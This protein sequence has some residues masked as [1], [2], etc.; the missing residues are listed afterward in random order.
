MT[1]ATQ[2]QTLRDALD[3]WAKAEGGSALIARDPV[4]MSQAIL[5]ARLKP[6]GIL[7]VVMFKAEEAV[8]D[9]PAAG[10]VR[11]TFTV[12]LSR[13]TGMTLEQS[14]SL[15]T[16]AGGGQ[17]LF[18]LVEAARELLRAL[19][20]TPAGAG[21]TDYADPAE[22][23][24]EYLGCKLFEWGGETLVDAYQLEFTLWTQLDAP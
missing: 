13:G 20:F 9:T 7:A 1:I 15:V 21:R 4:H 11:R 24:F 22:M 6:G 5:N 8:G 2:L 10:M 3:T 23:A 19:T 17:A 12:A 16:G 14:D 18:D